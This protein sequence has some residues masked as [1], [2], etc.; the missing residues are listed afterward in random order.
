M[1]ADLIAAC[2][3]NNSVPVAELPTLLVQVH[4][5]LARLLAAP[6][7]SEPEAEKATSVQIKKSIISDVLISFIDGKPSRSYPFRQVLTSASRSAPFRLFAEACA[8]QLLI[9]AC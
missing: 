7:V 9:L 4:G 2:V 3:S 6:A 8:V 1:T 5:A